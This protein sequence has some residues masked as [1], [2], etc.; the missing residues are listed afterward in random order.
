LSLRTADSRRASRC[1]KAIGS[2]I[3]SGVSVQAKPNIIPWSP[4]PWASNG[5]AAAAERSSTAESTPWA[6]SRDWAPIATL[7]PQEAPSK[8]LCEES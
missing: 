3:S 5:P 6:M 4:A 8:P 1:A 2:G 7:T